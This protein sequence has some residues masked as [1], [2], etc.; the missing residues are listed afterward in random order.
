MKIRKILSSLVMLSFLC[1]GPQQMGAAREPEAPANANA[2]LAQGS[3]ATPNLA[4]L[5]Q[6]GG[7]ARGIVVDGDYAYMGEGPHLDVLDLTNPS[8]PD[9]IGQSALLPG[10]IQDLDMQGGLVYAAAGEA[11]LRI[12][13]PDDP[14]QPVEIGHYDIPGLTTGLDISGTVAYVLGGE[15]MHTIDISDPSHPVELDTFGTLDLVYGIEIS[16][17]L[18]IHWW[19]GGLQVLDVSDPSDLSEVGWISTPGGVGGVD[20]EG[21]YAYVTDGSSGLRI[22]DISNV[23]AMHEEGYFATGDIYF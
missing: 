22:I 4:L 18:C 7:E 5:G 19:L 14:T 8:S 17:S 1:F 9:L 21:N 10:T 2:V 6:I 3:R 12:F 20:V 13:D 11:G 23:S 15:A 16:G